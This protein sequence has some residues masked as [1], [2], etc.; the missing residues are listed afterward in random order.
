LAAVIGGMIWLAIVLSRPAT[1]DELY[2]AITSK[3]GAAGDS[4]TSVESHLKDFFTRFPQDPRGAELRE[5][6]R[7]IAL[8]HA[9]R[10]LQ[11]TARRG[12]FA[13]PSL[14]PVEQLYLRATSTALDAPETGVRLLESLVA[15]YDAP[16]AENGDDARASDELGDRQAICVELARRELGSLRK[17]LVEE[18]K[19]Q[20]A[21][22]RERLDTADRLLQSER[23]RAVEMYRAIVD[24]HHDHAWAKD[25]VAEA[26]RRL[27]DQEKPQ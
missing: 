12:G 24:L 5:I 3:T 25:V 15:L 18:N 4:L 2:Q 26:R 9:Q 16:P 10:R 11:Q 8:E 1:A 6:E 21:A 13:D 20:L 17:A 19:R 14:L 7:R 27:A 23:P 22:L